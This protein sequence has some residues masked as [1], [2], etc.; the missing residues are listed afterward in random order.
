MTIAIKADDNSDFE[1]VSTKASLR[2]DA[3]GLYYWDFNR[4]YPAKEIRIWLN[5]SGE[6][7]GAGAGKLSSVT[8][9]E[10]EVW[11]LPAGAPVPDESH[12]ANVDTTSEM[13]NPGDGMWGTNRAQTLAL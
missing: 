13:F 4:Y 12:P 11:A 8:F 9:N 10:M 7:E 3:Q 1:V 2:R 6:G 5:S